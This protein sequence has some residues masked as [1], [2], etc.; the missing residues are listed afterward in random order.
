MLGRGGKAHCN[1][2]NDLCKKGHQIRPIAISDD[3]HGIGTVRGDTQAAKSRWYAYPLQKILRV[4]SSTPPVLAARQPE[5]GKGMVE[6]NVA[7]NEGPCWGTS[8]KLPAKSSERN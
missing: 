4:V 8:S 6:I 2:C 7:I 1:D 3:G 5:A